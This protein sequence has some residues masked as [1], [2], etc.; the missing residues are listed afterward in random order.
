MKIRRNEK[1]IYSE[2][3]YEEW[4]GWNRFA[5][6]PWRSELRQEGYQGRSVGRHCWSHCQDPGLRRSAGRECSCSLQSW[7]TH[8][9]SEFF[10]LLFSLLSLYLF[11]TFLFSLCFIFLLPLH[12][13]SCTWR[14]HHVPEPLCLRA[15][16]RQ[17]DFFH[18]LI[19]SQSTNPFG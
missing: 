16:H 13:P 17:H 12:P 2:G 1:V 6:A 18:L 3:G 4:G 5:P 19:S 8:L 15:S 14:W 7:R 9:P 10:I 11:C